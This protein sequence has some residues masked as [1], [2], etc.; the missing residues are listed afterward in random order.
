MEAPRLSDLVVEV[1]QVQQELLLQVQQ[2]VMVDV[3]QRIQLQDLLSL[4]QV[5]EEV[6]QILVVPQEQV[7][8]VVEEMV[9][10]LQVHQEPQELQI[11]VAAVEVKVLIQ[12][13][14]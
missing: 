6:L 11:Q 3:V 5:A 4:M 12:E 1:V 14:V 13:Q 7:D 2:Q 10:Y 9:E 8:P